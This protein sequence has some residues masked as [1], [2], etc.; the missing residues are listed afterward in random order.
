MTTRCSREQRKIIISVALLTQFF[1]YRPVPN[2][3][4]VLQSTPG[5]T[6]LDAANDRTTNNGSQPPENPSGDGNNDE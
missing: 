3:A 6:T 2:V 4:V 5:N 1:I